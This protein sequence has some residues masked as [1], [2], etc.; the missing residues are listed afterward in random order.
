MLNIKGE[1]IVNGLLKIQPAPTP[2]SN[3]LCVPISATVIIRPW[4][5]PS[6]DQTRVV[7]SFYDNSATQPTLN[8]FYQELN[9]PPF[10]YPNLYVYQDGMAENF[11][12]IAHNNWTV[13]AT[14]GIAYSFGNRTITPNTT[15]TYFDTH[16]L[17]GEFETTII[18][19]AL[20]NP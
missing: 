11:Y 3:V 12:V 1:T 16:P 18:W 7:P 2:T 4:G 15:Q 6:L 17:N 13:G 10:T 9:S 8:V 20:Y 5:T 19:G 14:G